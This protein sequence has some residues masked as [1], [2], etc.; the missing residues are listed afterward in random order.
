VGLSPLSLLVSPLVLYL[1]VVA[2]LLQRIRQV[3][4]IALVVMSLG[5]VGVAAFILNSLPNQIAES[6]TAL[7]KNRLQQ[8]IRDVYNSSQTA[9]P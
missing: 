3:I 6:K 9:Q 7:E 5:Y 4:A 2:M 8:E 1:E